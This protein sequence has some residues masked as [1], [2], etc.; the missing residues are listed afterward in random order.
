[1]IELTKGPSVDVQTEA[2]WAVVNPSE[3]GTIDQNWQLIQM[4][5]LPPLMDIL[6]VTGA[7]PKVRACIIE[8]VCNLT[9]KFESGG[10]LDQFR[11]KV[12]ENNGRAA[13][14]RYMVGNPISASTLEKLNSLLSGTDELQEIN[15]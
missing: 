13:I 1:V 12:L 3:G 10:K 5:M 2:V 6:A 14:I 11:E 9:T 7:T 15:T 4:G 8:G